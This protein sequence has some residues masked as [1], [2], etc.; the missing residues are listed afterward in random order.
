MT[1]KQLQNRREKLENQLKQMEK[2]HSKKFVNIVSESAYRDSIKAIDQVYRKL[3]AVCQELGD[4]I[5][6]RF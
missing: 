6:V 5:S 1:K 3:F 4:P 2:V